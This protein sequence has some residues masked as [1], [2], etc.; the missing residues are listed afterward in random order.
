[1]LK[2]ILGLCVFGMV[3]AAHAQL[4]TDFNPPR[5]NCCLA[6]T[7]QN[8]ADQL[9]DWNQLGRY[10]AANEELKKMPG[11][12]KRIVFMGDSITDS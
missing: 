4:V 7:A 3:T 6:G 9:K 10:H 2:P 11:D 8:L 1:M 5:A 12:P